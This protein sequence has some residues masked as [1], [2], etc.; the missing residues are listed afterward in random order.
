[1]AKKN[2]R[3]KNVIDAHGWLGV[4]FSV[5]LFLVFWAGALSLFRLEIQQWAEQPHHL[6]DDTAPDKPLI[7]L[8]DST[9]VK[10]PFDASEHLSV[11]LPEPH[12]DH[13]TLFIDL[14]EEAAKESG[15]HFVGV[16]VDPKSGDVI[17]RW[18]QFQLADILF[19][20]HYNMK[21]GQIGTYFIG[22]VTLFFLF[23]L[24]SGIYIHARKLI[25]HFFA[26]RIKKRRTQLLDMHNVVGVISLPYTIMYAISGLIFNLIV[27]YQISFVMLEYQGDSA[28]LVQDAGFAPAVT[29]EFSGVPMSMA[30]VPQLIERTQAEHGHVRFIRFYNYGDENAVVQLRGHYRGLFADAFDIYYRLKDEKILHFGGVAHNDFQQGTDVI[31]ALHFGDFA[32]VDVRLVYF[33]LALVVL[34]MIVGGNLLWIDKRARQTARFPRATRVVSNMTLGGCAGLVVATAVMFLLERTVPVHWADRSG[35]LLN[36]FFV[37]TALVALAAFY[38]KGNLS[39]LAAML[40]LTAVIL[41]VTVAADWLLFG[42]SFT[43]FVQRGVITPLAVEAVMILFAITFIRVAALLSDSRQ[44]ASAISD[45]R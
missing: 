6:V 2:L 21:L 4:I 28:Q 33:V 24:F 3:L 39:F 26:Y 15:K 34:V 23:A 19:R 5:V 25:Q 22:I 16:K 14:S 20:L 12:R 38:I 29:E 31:A 37:V 41:T 35:Y 44:L 13:Y 7:P 32:G 10:Y 30:S 43:Q 27:V 17:G 42:A 11:M 8:I 40:R 36:A 18:E 9:V 1:M 45:V